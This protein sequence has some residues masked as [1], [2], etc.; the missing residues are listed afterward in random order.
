M[1]NMTPNIAFYFEN[2]ASENIEIHITAYEK[3]IM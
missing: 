3:V 2:I 1:K